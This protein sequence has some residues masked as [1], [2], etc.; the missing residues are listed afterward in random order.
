VTRATTTPPPIAA[1]DEQL[2]TRLRD[3]AL[4]DID[5]LLAG[6]AG[7]AYAQ[8]LVTYAEDL[9]DALR[10]AR[11]RLTDLSRNVIGA[12]PLSLLDA[13]FQTRAKDG[14]RE[15]AEKVG[16]RLATRA[17]ACRAHARIDDLASALFPRLLEADRRRASIAR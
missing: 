12:D 7:D 2:L 8:L 17:A 16:K 10:A 13:P 6:V 4:V 11:A 3:L 5:V 1:E 15:A 14:G 9:E